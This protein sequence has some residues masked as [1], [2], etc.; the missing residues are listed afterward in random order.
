MESIL[1]KKR[2]STNLWRGVPRKAEKCSRKAGRAEMFKLLS[3]CYVRVS[4]HLSCQELRLFYTTFDPS[5]FQGP[6]SLI[7]HPSAH[8]QAPPNCSGKF[9][10][11]ICLMSSSL[12]VP[13]KML[14][15]LTV[16]SSNQG[17]MTA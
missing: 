6:A 8:L 1:R 16:T 15:F 10:T 3:G 2:N 11:G 13:P 5:S 7:E 12:Y 17:L 4:N 14:I 9:W